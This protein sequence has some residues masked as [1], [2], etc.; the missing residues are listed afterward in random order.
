MLSGL[1]ARGFHGVFESERESGQ[2]FVVDLEI[3][4]D[5]PSTDSISDTVDYGKLAHSV[6]MVIAG[7]PVDLIE[8][9][10]ARI[11]SRVLEDSRIRRT[12]VTVHKPHAPI[13]VEFDDVAVTISR[14][15]RV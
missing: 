9:L 12:R 6:V 15:N 7:D 2:E 4:I 14:S 8:T 1:R 5:M 10:A 3:E 11:A 13:D